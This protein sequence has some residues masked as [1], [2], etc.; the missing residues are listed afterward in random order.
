MQQ[1]DNFLLSTDYRGA[2][3]GLFESYNST[4]QHLVH[5]CCHATTF[6]AAKSSEKSNR[7]STKSGVKRSNSEAQVT[8]M[9]DN[10]AV[11]PAKKNTYE[12]CICFRNSGGV[13]CQV[14]IKGIRWLH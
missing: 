9:D 13:P 12:Y 4:T 10:N 7:D 11:I 3:K 5:D 1:F 6:L 2:L 14:H 8:D